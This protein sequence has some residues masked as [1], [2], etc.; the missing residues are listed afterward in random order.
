MIPNELISVVVS[1]SRDVVSVTPNEL[2][3]VTPKELTSV[4]VTCGKEVVSVTLSGVNVSRG[5]VE[6]TKTVLAGKIE[7]CVK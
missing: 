1:G 2:I 6:V 7:V 4:L 5:S 3:S